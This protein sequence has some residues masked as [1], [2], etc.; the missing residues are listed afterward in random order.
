MEKFYNCY[1][2]S[3]RV[4]L[5]VSNP[6]AFPEPQSTDALS[7]HLDILPTLAA[8]LSG[9]GGSNNNNDRQ[10]PLVDSSSLQGNDLTPILNNPQTTTTIA[11]SNKS[12][13]NNETR[14]TT[15]LGVQAS[16]H[17][18]Y[19]DI[20]CPGA[21]STI[22][23][24]H[25]GDLKY[26]VYFTPNGM[27]ADWELYDLSVDPLENIN[28][29]ADP[30][31]R[32]VRS[33]MEQELYDTMVKKGTLPRG[34]RW[35]PRGTS[36]SRGSIQHPPPEQHPVSYE[37]F[38]EGPFATILLGMKDARS[39]C[40]N[41]LMEWGVSSLSV[42]VQNYDATADVSLQVK[43]LNGEITDAKYKIEDHGLVLTLT[44]KEPGAKWETVHSTVGTQQEN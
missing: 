19:D 35:P 29:A 42:V 43:R 4:P 24:L 28:V 13:S 40:T 6:L 5:V 41:V 38:D 23:C 10:A 8:L 39:K 11:G 30:D 37:F 21:P 34:F 20:P 26:A 16:I 1:Q 32:A 14:E 27:D 2:E 22:R 9:G 25:R 7:S 18:T 33:D 12:K 44:K 31:Y 17:F 36:R 3:L 15:I